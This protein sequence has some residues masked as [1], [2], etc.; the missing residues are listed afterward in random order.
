MYIQIGEVVLNAAVPK[1]AE[2]KRLGMMG[3]RFDSGFDAMLFQFEDIHRSFWMKNC[4]IPLDMIF[5]LDGVVSSIAYNCPPCTTD[6]CVSYKGL[7]QDVIEVEGGRCQALGI[8]VG[9]AVKYSK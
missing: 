8:A 6:P 9:D 2:G 1:T 3:R 5:V 7:G 4:I